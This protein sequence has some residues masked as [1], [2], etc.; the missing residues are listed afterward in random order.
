MK[1]ILFGY[2]PI[3]KKV[4]N[5]FLKNPE[6]KDVEIEGVISYKKN[7]PLDLYYKGKKINE[8]KYKNYS[9]LG[10]KIQGV[11][12]GICCCFGILP[13][14]VFNSPKNGIYNIHYS[15]LPDGKGMDP[16]IYS[17]ARF[18]RKTAVSIFKIN[19][20]IDT[21][22][23]LTQKEVKINLLDWICPIFLYRKLNKVSSCLLVDLLN[24]KVSTI[25]KKRKSTYYNK[26][27]TRYLTG[28]YL[29]EYYGFLKGTIYLTK[30]SRSL[31]SRNHINSFHKD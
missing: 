1:I 29:I 31:L 21:G 9:D 10:E 24:G 18:H 25:N 14:C 2:G 22:T 30:L 6:L 15:H 4:F 3:A 20:G 7:P 12:L 8:I 11:D 27:Q 19:A 13:K 16:I 23:I 5:D 28:L 26:N 17:L